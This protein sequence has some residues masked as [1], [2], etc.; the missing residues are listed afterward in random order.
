MFRTCFICSQ[1]AGTIKQ[2]KLHLLTVHHKSIV[3]L[4]CV[5]RKGWSHEFP[6]QS[7]Y[8]EHYNFSHSGLIEARSVKRNEQKQLLKKQKRQE[9]EKE[10]LLA[11]KRLESE[12]KIR[13]LRHPL[14][15]LH[16]PDHPRF[17]SGHLKD[18]HLV[19][20]HGYDYCKL[21]KVGV[22]RHL[23]MKSN[24]IILVAGARSQC[25]CSHCLSSR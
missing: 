14:T 13:R 19:S 10:R 1:S 7:S 25:S 9:R 16:C 20:K 24:H 11:S 23:I 6:S 21:C 15:C 8:N 4:F 12:K 3:C 5:E 18:R 17:G 2:L 22:V